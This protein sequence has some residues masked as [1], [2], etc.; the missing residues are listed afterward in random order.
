MKRSHLVSLVTALTLFVMEVTAL[1]A[2]PST[3]RHSGLAVS[4]PDASIAVK[5]VAPERNDLGAG[6][7]PDVILP[8]AWAFGVLHGYYTNQAGISRN[9]HRLERGDFPVD[10]IWV[11]SAF[12]D[13]TTRGPAGYL[14]FKGDLRAFPSLRQL[15]SELARHQV[16]F[17]IW[18]W[19]RILDANA[20]V[21]AEF[22]SRGFFKPDR[23]VS[24]GWHNVGLTSVARPVDFHSAAAAALWG[25]K[26]RPFLDNGVD[27]FKIDAE[28][29]TDY[30]RTHFELSQRHGRHTRGRGFVLTQTARGSL[31]DIKR[32]PAAWTGDAQSSWHQADYPDTSRWI[33]GGL[34]QQIEMVANPTWRHYQYPFLANDTG[35]FHPRALQGAAAEELYIRWAQFSAFGSIMQV[36]G[37]PSVPEQN[38]PFGWSGTVQENFRTHTH[39]RLRLFPYIYTHALLTRLTGRKMIQGDAEHR[40][41]Y[42]FGS[43]FLV[44]PVHEPGAS[45]RV[46]W[47]PPGQ[48][49]I[50]YWTGDSYEGGQD[51]TIP[52]PLSHLPLLVRAGAIIPMREYAPSVAR[53]DNATLILDIYPEGAKQPSQFTLYE[54]DGISNDYL[55]NRFTSTLVVCEPALQTITLKIAPICGDYNGKPGKRRWK[56]EVHLVSKPAEVSLNGKPTAWRY[57]AKKAV[58]R[59]DW[60]AAT[61]EASEVRISR[62]SD[63]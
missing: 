47:L 49:W 31:A 32:Y 59:L 33:L 29:Q 28:P 26:L 58:L 17:G 50:D 52:A 8:P 15:T 23:I 22:D 7:D 10:A 60:K 24:N 56:L 11:D 45:N 19:D 39:L 25:E 35:G 16:K 62:G 30:L 41:Q 1:T 43:E 55:A 42:R 63:A 53:G 51:V 9:L 13:L 6:F 14:D 5:E 40:F 12:W 37:G 61:A 18:V 46:V 44:A 38:A 2:T 57:D 48:R 54:D 20:E 36:F 4:G 21:F 27:F 34:R 3:N